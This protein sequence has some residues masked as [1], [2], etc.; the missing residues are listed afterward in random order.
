MNK[1]P[2][3]DLFNDVRDAFL[4]LQKMRFKFDQTKIDKESI[5]M[6]MPEGWSLF[7]LNETNWAILNPSKM[8]EVIIY[9]LIN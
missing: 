6:V 5:S 7:N 9:I 4:H 8:P 3:P 2:N 1:F